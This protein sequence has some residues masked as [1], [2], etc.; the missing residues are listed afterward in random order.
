MATMQDVAERAGVTKQTVSNVLSGRVPVR[1]TTAARVRAAISE[2]GYTPNLVARSLATGSTRTVGLFVPTVTGT[3]YAEVVEAVEDV[4]EEHGYHLLLCT[5]RLDGERARRHLAGL[6][7][8]SVEA[9]LIAGDRDLIDHL[10]LLADARFP[11]ALC[12]WE[13]T[14]PDAFPVVTVDYEHAGYLAGRH[15]RE[16]GHRRVA[17]LA[18]PAH[19]TRV[20]GFRRGFTAEGLA[21]PDDAVHLAAE[22]TLAGGFAAAQAAFAADPGLTAVF[23]THD[24]LALGALEAAR[25]AGRAVP[26]DL[27]VVGHDDTPEVRLTRPP[28]TTVAL[29]KREMARQAVELLLRA[30]A[31]SAGTVNSLQL[32]RPELVVRDSTCPPRAPGL[33]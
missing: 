12:A 22:P 3:F 19:T 18:S 13:T 10:P 17:V 20:A 31:K 14:A 5:T 8:R 25:A 23:A 27:S 26:Q 21:V 33:G 15:L 1:P 28:L 16:L 29:P 30:L 4:L 11:V 6:T 2:L 7:S 32:L 24:I 9:L